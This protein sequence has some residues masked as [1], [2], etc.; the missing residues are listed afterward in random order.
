MA[1]LSYKFS[2]NDLLNYLNSD[3]LDSIFFLFLI[4]TILIS[5]AIFFHFHKYRFH[6]PINFFVEIIY[7][8]GVLL[9]LGLAFVFLILFSK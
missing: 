8:I 1:S 9:F 6:S 2:I 3:H 7:L 5:V 4:L